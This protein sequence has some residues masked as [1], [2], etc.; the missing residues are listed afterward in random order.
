M[1]SNLKVTESDSKVGQPLH[2]SVELENT[3]SISADEVVELYM[4]QQYGSASRPVRE[5]KGFQ[6][7]ALAPHTRTSVEFT[8]N[9]ADFRFWS[10]ATNAWVED[11]SAF[12]LWV[13]GDSN[14]TL[15]TTFTHTIAT[16]K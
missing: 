3:G 13:G 15:H 9:S 2:V 16:T 5:L 10:A 11:A 8:V 6:R 4:H 1:Y 7:V 12:D 14:A